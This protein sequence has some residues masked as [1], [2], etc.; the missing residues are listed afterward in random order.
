MKTSRFSLLRSFVLTFFLLQIF[1]PVLESRSNPIFNHKVK[2][3]LQEQLTEIRDIQ[4]AGNR[5][6]SSVLQKRIKNKLESIFKTLRRHIRNQDPNFTASQEKACLKIAED[7]LRDA[8][9]MG[10]QNRFKVMV[11]LSAKDAFMEIDN[12]IYEEIKEVLKSSQRDFQTQM[13]LKDIN[14]ELKREAKKKRIEDLKNKFLEDIEAAKSNKNLG[15]AA[16]V[17]VRGKVLRLAG[18]LRV[19]LN[20]ELSE[21]PGSDSGRS[22]LEKSVKKRRKKF[23]WLLVSAGVAVTAVILY[24]VM[25]NRGEKD[26]PDDRR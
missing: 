4:S 25:K 18:V 2:S 15:K 14:Q 3:W 9:D 10:W 22:I 5:S 24:L 8:E 20:P 26:S 11:S 19:E 16:D 12:E 1:C 23:P 21:T 17:I 13:R 6:P 7:A